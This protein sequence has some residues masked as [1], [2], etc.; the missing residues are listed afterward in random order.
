MPGFFC[1]D[2]LSI[3][4]TFKNLEESNGIKVNDTSR[5]QKRE[6]HIDT[7]ISLK[8][9]PAIPGT[10]SIGK[11]TDMVVNVEAIIA[12]DTS[13]VPL[14]ELSIIPAPS[15]RYRKMFSNTT[16]ELSTSIPTANARPAMD[17]ILRVISARSKTAKV[18]TIDMG[19][20]R[21]TMIEARI[22]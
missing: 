10:K 14:S 11:K 13:L 1:T 16:M 3:T 15:L 9:T 7:A 2:S 17:I 19:M 20:E 18:T 21:A 6:K 12:V 22:L 5:A 8:R 4:A